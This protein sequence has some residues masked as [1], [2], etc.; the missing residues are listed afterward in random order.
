MAS[1]V[2][3]GTTIRN[4]R[5]VLMREHV[6]LMLKR[7]TV[8]TRNWHALLEPP[9]VEHGWTAEAVA[10]GMDALGMAVSA[11][12][13]HRRRRH[14]IVR[15]LALRTYCISCP[16]MTCPRKD[17]TGEESWTRPTMHCMRILR[18][19]VHKGATRVPRRAVEGHIVVLHGLKL[20]HLGRHALWILRVHAMRLVRRV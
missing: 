16:G 4:R 7:V 19:R 9:L 20:V 17:R 12:H 14:G 15:L 6:R 13:F 5:R 2:V 1:D 11:R 3:L 8:R 10:V 18:P